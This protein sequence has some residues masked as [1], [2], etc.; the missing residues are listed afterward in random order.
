MRG[1]DWKWQNQ[2]SGEGHVGTV[3]EIGKPGSTTSPDKTVVVQWDSGS[4]TNYRVGYQGAHDLR[5]ID[6]APIGEYVIFTA[7]KRSLG[8]G[9]IFTPVCHSV[10]RGG[11]P[12]QVPPGQ[13]HPPGRYTPQTRYNLPAG[14]SACWEIRATSGRYASYG[15]A[16]LFTFVFEMCNNLLYEDYE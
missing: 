14:S 1:P 2:D 16:F 4:R 13:V 8:Q 12:G 3:V 9:N 6:N 5:V 7:R 10:H 15:N 11:V